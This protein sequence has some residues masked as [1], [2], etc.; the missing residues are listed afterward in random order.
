M[1]NFILREI[2]VNNSLNTL[3]NEFK[4]INDIFESFGTEYLRF[5]YL[6]KSN[7]FISPEPFYIGNQTVLDNV[8]VPGVKIKKD[9]GQKLSINQKLKMF[10]ELPNVYQQIL[11]Y[12]AEEALPNSGVISSIIHGT[13]WKDLETRFE[14]KTFF[15]LLLF[16]DDFEPCNPLGSRAVIYKLGAVYITL[17]CLPPE[18]SSLLEN[19]FLAQLT[20]TSDKE[21]YG[22]KKIFSNLIEDLKCLEEDGINIVINNDEKK[23]YFP[24]I[25]ILGDNLGLNSVLGFSESFRVPITFVAS[26]LLIEI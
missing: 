8:S 24:L 11:E 22:N 3:E 14:N 21:V 9:L 17:S 13:L 19:I 5:E 6:K 18:Y 7:S 20:Y 15:P 12:I 16:Y 4:N 23:V 10:L 26:V 1:F 2:S 25:L